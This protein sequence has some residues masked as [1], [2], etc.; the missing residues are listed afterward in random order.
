MATVNIDTYKLV[1]KN[2]TIEKDADAQLDYGFDWTK[3]LDAVGDTIAAVDFVVDPLLA[4]VN[5]SHDTKTATV[6]LSGGA[7]ATA[8]L[9]VTCRITTTNTPPRIDDRSIFLK[10]VP[11]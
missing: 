3:Y 8:A 9:R 10:I 5:E 1:G 7:G 2:W 6:W 4:K 11:K